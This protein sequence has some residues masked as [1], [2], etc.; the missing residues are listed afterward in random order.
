MLFAS[1]KALAQ[2]EATRALWRAVVTVEREQAFVART[3]VDPLALDE[4]VIIDLPDE[5]YLLLARGPFDAPAVVRMAGERLAVVDVS[6]DKPRMRRE[7]LAGAGRYAY[8]ALD[9]HTV[10]VARDAPPELVGQALARVDAPSV[11][12]AFEQPLAADLRREQGAVPLVVYE[13]KPLHLPLDTS[14]GV[15]LAEE[16]ALAIGVTPSTDQLQVVV[17]L[18]GELPQGAESNLRTWARNIGATDLGRVLGL[19][20]VSEEMGIR[21]DASGALVRF[22]VHAADLISGVRLL[23]FDEMRRIFE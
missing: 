16:R 9:A 18:R 10:L 4:L 12:G 3:A 8:A 21:V 2:V 11:H 20:R 14:V 17:D 23:F 19:S 7:G 15:L 5:A 1:P 13:L 22:R 6:V